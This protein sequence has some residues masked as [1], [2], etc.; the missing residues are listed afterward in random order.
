MGWYWN[1]L[2]STIRANKTPAG[3]KA[4]A[5]PLMRKCKD[6]RMAAAMFLAPPTSS[7]LYDSYLFTAIACNSKCPPRRSD[8]APMN[9]RAG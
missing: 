9:S 3:L 8:P 2:T 1:L 5:N 7:T 4:T 6:G